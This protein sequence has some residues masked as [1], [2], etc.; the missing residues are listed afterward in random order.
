MFQ[1]N[2]FSL[3]TGKP[4][5]KDF[6]LYAVL[7]SLLP[8]LSQDLP[9]QCLGSDAAVLSINCKNGSQAN[10]Q[11]S[12]TSCHCQVI[13]VVNPICNSAVW[14]GKRYINDLCQKGGL[15]ILRYLRR[16]WCCPPQSQSLVFYGQGQSINGYLEK[17]LHRR[18]CQTLEW[19]A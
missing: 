17:F 18:V 8:S 5:Q 1:E 3:P 10:S 9:L 14:K 13:I 16:N 6:Q 19:A 12:L 4:S 2:F 11:T 7:P 15:K